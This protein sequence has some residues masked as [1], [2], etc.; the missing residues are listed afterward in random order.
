M[1]ADRRE[2]EVI[3]ERGALVVLRMES[4]RFPGVLLA[5]DTLYTWL[6]TLNE[7]CESVGRDSA[8]TELRESVEQFVWGYIDVLR[9]AHEPLPFELPRDDSDGAKD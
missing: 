1:A 7:A 8:L 6:E 3:A 2:V 5:G 9:S 4:R